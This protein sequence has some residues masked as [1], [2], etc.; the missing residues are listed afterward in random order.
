MNVLIAVH[1]LPSLETS[2]VT[3]SE[4]ALPKLAVE[5]TKVTV[6][7]PVTPLV[8]NDRLMSDVPELAAKP[9][10]LLLLENPVLS[11]VNAPIRTLA[12]SE[13][14]QSEAQV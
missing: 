5:Y 6:A 3:D 7:S 4:L 12:V 11:A 10:I 8:S 9:K 2:R 14:T 1:V 13:E